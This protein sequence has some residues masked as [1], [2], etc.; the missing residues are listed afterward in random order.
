VKE[1]G[2]E[3]KRFEKDLNS[4]EVHKQLMANTTLAETLK[5]PGVPTIF[6]IQ[7]NGE[8]VIVPP[9]DIKEFNKLIDNL[10]IARPLTQEDNPVKADADES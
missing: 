9:T 8:L 7:N 6:G 2:L 10:K 4:E 1:A 3:A 5:I